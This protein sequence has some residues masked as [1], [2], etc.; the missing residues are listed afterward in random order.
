MLSIFNVHILINDRNI[1]SLV[2]VHIFIK[3]IYFQCDK[4]HKRFCAV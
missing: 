3:I 2:Q 1:D 4:K